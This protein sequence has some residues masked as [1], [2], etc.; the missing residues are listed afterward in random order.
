MKRIFFLGLILSFALSLQA[1][2]SFLLTDKQQKDTLKTTIY[3]AGDGKYLLFKIQVEEG[4]KYGH[5]TVAYKNGDI[6]EGDWLNGE[7]VGQGTITYA[8]GVRY[9]GSWKNDKRDGEGT[10]YYKN[11]NLWY[12]GNWK[13]DKRDG[14][15]TVYYMDG[16]RYSGNWKNG[17]RD[18]QGTRYYTNDTNGD[19]YEGNWKNGERDGR[20]T[21]YYANGDRYEGNWLN[22][23][24]DGQGTV[25]YANGDRYKGNLL[26]GERVGQGTM[27]YANGD[28]YEGEWK[29]DEQGGKG[30]VYYAN[31]DRFEGHW[32][33]GHMFG[34]GTYF[35]KN[36][37]WYEGLWGDGK[38]IESG[39]YHWKSGARLEGRYVNGKADREHYYF[40]AGEQTAAEVWVY[41]NGEEIET[42][43]LRMAAKTTS[44]TPSQTKSNTI[45]GHEYVDLGLPSG[46]LWATCNVGA[47][48]PE[49]YGDYFAWGETT[50]KSDYFWYTYTYCDGTSITMTKY[51]TD[52][53]LGTVDNKITLEA[54]DDA[55]T[56]NWGGAWRMPTKAEQ[57]ELRSECTWSWT[58]LN[59]VYGCRITSK[60]DTSKSIFL[61]AAGFRF[62]ASLGGAG[63]LGCYWSSSLLESG[64]NEACYLTFDSYSYG[65]NYNGRH[66][67]LS[68]RPVCSPQ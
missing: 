14:Q 37:D 12:S 5:A 45:N 67:G 34:Q 32:L 58:T 17:K 27:Y 66:Y 51:C 55:A 22:D 61:P 53:S 59:D 64:L 63:S 20:G 57:D 21:V 1:T 3:S 60:K 11:G 4:K 41:K 2:E 47:T 56:A 7:R 9:V 39:V 30:I 26:N 10:M 35:W 62:G 15:G 38:R 46:T 49:D 16:S 33:Y 24:Q 28:R 42:R 18:G 13:N 43:D 31:G 6:Y 65:W 50:T 52:S 25:Y 68:V 23:K 54:S 48:S 36:G 44:T 19:R 29:D 40:K 8:N